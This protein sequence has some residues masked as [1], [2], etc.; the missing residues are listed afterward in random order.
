MQMITFDLSIYKLLKNSLI[1]ALVGFKRNF[2][3]LLGIICLIFLEY[4][5]LFGLGGMLLPLGLALPLVAL[6]ACGAYMGGFASYFKIKEIMIDPYV[7]E[8]SEDE[9]INEPV[10]DI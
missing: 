3:A 8:N 1:F 6:F 4:A 7:D 2:M 5:L 9:E 10:E